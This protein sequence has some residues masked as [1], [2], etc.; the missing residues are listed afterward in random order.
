MGD[1]MKI[2]DSHCHLDDSVFE[3]DFSEVLHRATAEGV[4]AVMTVAVD[5][6]SAQKAVE[7][8]SVHPRVFA[9][10]GVHPHDAGACTTAH[11]ELL[12]KLAD[13]P[14]V[15]AWGEIGLDYNRMYSDK[16][17]QDRWFARQIE[18]AGQL[19][20]PMILHE[21]DS[22]GRFLSLLKTHM[23]AHQTGVVHCFSGNRR[24]LDA[25][26]EMGLFL[27]ITGILT[28]KSR[29]RQ[30]REMV[31]WIPPERLLVE[32][33][34]PYLTPSPQKNKCRRNEPAFVKSVLMEL[35]RVCRQAPSVLADTLWHTTCRLFNIAPDDVL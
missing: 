19:G 25:Y 21:R 17:H 33:D 26:L 12:A 31:R 15:R 10:V 5:L 16:T 11:L 3:S 8:A 7:L 1:D 24:E 35:A 27:G 9:A 13:T 29:G 22:N 20:L 2:F 18:M 30:L 6:Q 32:T 23:T 4:L 34:A 14:K 28:M